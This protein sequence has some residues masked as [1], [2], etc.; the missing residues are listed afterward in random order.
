MVT[1]LVECSNDP[2][3]FTRRFHQ[4]SNPYY[5]RSTGMDVWCGAAGTAAAATEFRS[6]EMRVVMRGSVVVTKAL[7]VKRSKQ[8]TPATKYP[9]AQIPSANETTI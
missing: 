2:D 7:D 6:V 1:L 9:S 3:S 4:T 5:V 8:S